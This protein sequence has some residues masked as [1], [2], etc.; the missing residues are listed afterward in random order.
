M[1][2]HKLTLQAVQKNKNKFVKQ[3]FNEIEATIALAVEYSPLSDF[4]FLI[5]KAGENIN[6]ISTVEDRSSWMPI[7][8]V[9]R[10]LA[11]IATLDILDTTKINEVKIEKMYCGC[12]YFEGDI[13]LTLENGEKIVGAYRWQWT[14]FQGRDRHFN[15]FT[16][17]PEIQVSEKIETEIN[18]K[19]NE[20]IPQN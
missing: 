6:L 20:L 16:I 7:R 8:N 14:A 19:I 4:S 1:G 5:N 2:I 12:D 9:I 3:L 10:I 17:F 18:S 11:K 15:K 13:S